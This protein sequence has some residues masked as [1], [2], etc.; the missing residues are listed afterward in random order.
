LTIYSSTID[1]NDSPS[2]EMKKSEEYAA[3]FAG[4]KYCKSSE[5]A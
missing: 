3:T 4:L 2:E 5:V 1:T